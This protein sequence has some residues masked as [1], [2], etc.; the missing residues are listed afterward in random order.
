MLWEG[1]EIGTEVDRQI[2]LTEN[3]TRMVSMPSMRE[4]T[5]Y[6]HNNAMTQ[7]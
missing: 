1:N 3:T 7:Y 4:T 5:I 6:L 2:L